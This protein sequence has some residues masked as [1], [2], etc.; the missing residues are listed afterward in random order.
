MCAYKTCNLSFVMYV[1]LRIQTP[2]NA[3]DVSNLQMAI[4]RILTTNHYNFLA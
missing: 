4:P 3:N 2:S 1:H